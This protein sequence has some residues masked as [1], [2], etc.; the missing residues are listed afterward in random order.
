LL[1][2]DLPIVSR[3]GRRLV[4]V[5][6]RPERG[7][8]RSRRNADHRGAGLAVSERVLARR[9]EL[10]PVMGVLDRA[11]AQPAIAKLAHQLTHETRLAVTLSAQDMEALPIDTTPRSSV[12]R[13]ITPQ[14]GA[15]NRRRV[16]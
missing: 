13:R 6:G 1:R 9:I 15:V 11:D 3:F 10:V 14:C 2:K 4:G 8:H 7:G 16:G 12:L 5:V